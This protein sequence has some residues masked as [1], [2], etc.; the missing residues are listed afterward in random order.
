MC[1]RDR[2]LSHIHFQKELIAAEWNEEKDNWKVITKDGSI[3]YSK[4]FTTAIGQLHHPSTPNFKGKDSFEGVA[5]HSAQ[6]NHEISLKNKIVG[7]IGTGASASQF[8]PQVAKE[9]KQVIIF[10]R[11]PNWMLPKQDRLYKNWEKQLVRRFP[12]L[13]KMYRL[14]LWL[15]GGALFILMKDG[16]HYLRKVYQSKTKKYI[17]ENIDD[18]EL[19][20]KLVPKYPLGAKRVLFSDDYYA[21]LNQ[22]NVTLITESIQEI[23]FEGL[24]TSNG[25]SHQMEVMVF[26]TG[27]KTNP[28]LLG[29]DI[30]GRNG[31]TIQEAWK[32][33]PKN[34]LGITVN[35]F[36][37]LF[38]MY[39]PNTNLGH[40]SIIIMSEAQANYIVQCVDGLKKN[41]WKSLEVKKEV[42]QKYHDSIQERLRNMIWTKIE[43]SWYQSKNGDIPNNWPGRTMEYTRR[44]RRV[45]FSDFD[46]S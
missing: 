22:K 44:T 3:F 43:M 28:F 45:D 2:I 1:I 42:L 9:A 37:N 32:D 14:K 4:T 21:S 46:I 10:Q 31:I 24:K 34:Y 16:N 11:S 20:K 18:L 39:G 25:I 38:M 5:F 13:L 33:S 15:L 12:F 27:F 7:I 19:R 35:D 40:N 17:R 36:P 29:I 8:I 26:G 23:N 41:N 6:W 30:K